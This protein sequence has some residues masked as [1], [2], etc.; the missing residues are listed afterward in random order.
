M[1]E[2]R[3][4]KSLGG[5]GFGGADIRDE[6]DGRGCVYDGVAL[7]GVNV[8]IDDG[9]VLLGGATLAKGYR[10]PVEPDPFAEPGWFAPMTLAPL[11]IQGC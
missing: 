7:D 1:P 4:R 2:R 5:S 9:R 10:N 8:R 11:M 3:C 6:R